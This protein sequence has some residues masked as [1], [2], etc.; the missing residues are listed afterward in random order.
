MYLARVEHETRV[1]QESAAVD[2]PRTP[3]TYEGGYKS[4]PRT[5]PRA[6]RGMFWVLGR[7]GMVHGTHFSLRSFRYA[8][9]VPHFPIAM[10]WLYFVVAFVVLGRGPCRTGGRALAGIWRPI[11]GRGSKDDG[12]RC[13]A[14]LARRAAVRLPY[15][16]GCHVYKIG[17]LLVRGISLPAAQLFVIAIESILRG[18]CGQFNKVCYL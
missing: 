3:P 13:A 11:G 16:S 4:M 15:Q 9:S 17:C 8:P 10:K 5:A 12:A 2:R 14:A 1:K 6:R 7:A 18:V